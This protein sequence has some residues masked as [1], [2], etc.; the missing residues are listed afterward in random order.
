MRVSNFRKFKKTL[1]RQIANFSVEADKDVG[2]DEWEMP[3]HRYS[4]AEILVWILNK[5]GA[6]LRKSQMVEAWVSV[7]RQC[8]NM[9][10]F[11]QYNG[12]NHQAILSEIEYFVQKA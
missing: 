12:R 8:W 3:I 2:D 10:D 4:A 9:Q 5:T 11:S 6:T 7:V 1:P